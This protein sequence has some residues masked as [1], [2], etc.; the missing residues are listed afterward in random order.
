LGIFW[1]VWTV[2]QRDDLEDWAREWLDDRST[3]FGKHLPIPRGNPIDRRAIFWFR[4]HSRL[5]REVWHLVAVLREQ[6][7]AVRLRRTSVP[8]RIVYDDPF[9]IAAIPY[10]HGRRPRKPKLPVLL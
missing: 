9:Q 6:G 10:G 2:E 5:V 4:P 7:V 1:A 3:W 8:G